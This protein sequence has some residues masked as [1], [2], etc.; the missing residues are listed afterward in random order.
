MAEKRYE[1]NSR[2]PM[3]MKLIRQIY[4]SS[5]AI[6]Q[7]PA[8]CSCVGKW[9]RI[10]DPNTL[11][12]TIGMQIPQ[13]QQQEDEQEEISKGEDESGALPKEGN[14]GVTSSSETKKENEVK[15]TS[16]DEKKNEKPKKLCVL[17]YVTKVTSVV[18][19]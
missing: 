10:T 9:L 16:S 15:E 11:N 12:T 2:G 19:G 13:Q 7:V 18:H 3:G 6:A 4:R 5:H 14:D 8:K 1:T 17:E